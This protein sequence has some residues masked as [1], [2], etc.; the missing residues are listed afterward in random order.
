M[1]LYVY[2]RTKPLASSSKYT[3]SFLQ[4]S[5]VTNT[6]EELPDQYQ[7]FLLLLSLT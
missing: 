6:V 4:L 2:R 1:L 7:R 5:E 3:A